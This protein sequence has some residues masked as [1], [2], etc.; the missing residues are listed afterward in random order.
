MNANAN[1]LRLNL[2]VIDSLS[3]ENSTKELS[4]SIVDTEFQIEQKTFNFE[5]KKTN[6][7]KVI[8]EKNC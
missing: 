1:T 4:I 8:L 3:K 6:D 7:F 5:E 2:T